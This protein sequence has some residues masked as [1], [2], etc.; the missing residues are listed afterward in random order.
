MPFEFSYRGSLWNVPW[1]WDQVI[2][3]QHRFFVR[4]YDSV[5]N[6]YCHYRC[7]Y[8]DEV[9][10]ALIHSALARETR[11][12]IDLMD[13]ECHCEYWEDKQDAMEAWGCDD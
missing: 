4:L 7:V 6:D 12:E 10:S 3:P 13:P 5:A 1:I 9:L 8:D 2:P 11:A